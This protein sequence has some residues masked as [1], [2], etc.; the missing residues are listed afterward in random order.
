MIRL[1]HDDGPLNVKRGTCINLPSGFNPGPSDYESTSACSLIYSYPLSVLVLPSVS[2]WV[3]LL[4]SERS[5]LGL[6][7]GHVVGPI[8]YKKQIKAQRT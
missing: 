2:C 5:V 3:A 6:V 4:V 8:G 1:C 7:A